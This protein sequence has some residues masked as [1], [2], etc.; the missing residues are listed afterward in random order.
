MDSPFS[1]YVPAILA[2]II[3]TALSIGL[4][5]LARQ[6]GL[7]DVPNE[8]KVHHGEI[9]LVGGIAI[10]IGVLSAHIISA[11][12]SPATVIGQHYLSFYAAASLLLLVGLVD[13]YWELK[14]TTK[15][16]AQLFAASIMVFG[17]G[18]VVN[19]LGSL[20]FTSG[21]VTLGMFAVPFTLF[22]TVGVVNAVNMS[23]GLDGL[24]GSLTLV[25]L[26]G[27]YI[28]TEWYGTGLY[29]DLLILTIASVTA[30]LLFN[31][32]FPGKRKALIFLG[33]AGSMLLGLSLV[34]FAISLSQGTDSAI[35]P[36]AA[37]WFLMVPIFDAASMILRRVT[38]RRSVFGADK[39]HLHHVF[40]LAG[41]TVGETVLTMASFA[42]VGVLVG[43][44]GSHF[45]ISDAVLIGAFVV[46]GVLYFWMIMR[47]W[48]VMR[49]LRR[50]ICRRR[51]ISDRR[52]YVER[53]RDLSGSYFGPE[54]RVGRDRRRTLYGRRRPK[55]G[56]PDR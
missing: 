31:V 39:E 7:V 46:C 2:F 38:R 21:A 23:D 36:G 6:I 22:A 12:F 26:L 25:P 30:F 54:R 9:P 16:I 8:R 4:R 28:A 37:L 13:D 40:L 41:F 5:P 35:R 44:A 3:T 50:S 11:V 51:N 27:F 56:Q 15:L 33:D 48:S 1:Q 53:R 52:T 49:F 43:L 10:F 34:W 32:T 24:A 29:A 19:E 45:E 42:L 18:V 20:G 14:P 47:A 17:G 55:T